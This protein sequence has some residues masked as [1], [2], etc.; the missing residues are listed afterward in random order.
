M[1]EFFFW[2]FGLWLL[3]G[4]TLLLLMV[5]VVMPVVW[6]LMERADEFWTKVFRG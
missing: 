3:M 4:I 2:A 1:S 5:T 6:H